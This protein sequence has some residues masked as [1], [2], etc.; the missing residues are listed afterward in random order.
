MKVNI[1]AGKIENHALRYRG[2]WQDVLSERVGARQRR[3]SFY[4]N[5]K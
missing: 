2:T 1:D 4:E 5:N 3:T